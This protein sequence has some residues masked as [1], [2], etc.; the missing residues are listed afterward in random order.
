M[1]AR[2]VRGRA[3]R[4][5][6]H[7]HDQHHVD[8]DDHHD[9]VL[10]RDAI[11]DLHRCAPAC[12]PRS[13]KAINTVA[14]T[15]A[16]ESVRAILMKE[17][18]DVVPA[19]GALVMASGDPVFP[20]YPK[21]VSKK[22]ID[23]RPAHSMTTDQVVALAPGVYAAYNPGRSRPRHLPDRP[24]RG[25][26]APSAS[27][28]SPTRAGRAGTE[29]AP[30]PEAEEPDLVR[31]APPRGVIGVGSH[32]RELGDGGSCCCS[33]RKEISERSFYGG[34]VLTPG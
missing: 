15:P 13:P 30:A 32:G 10:G 12:A 11:V 28:T 8:V 9:R 17:C 19:A 1:G 14:G 4:G 3:R 6:G 18:G 20:G 16:N 7:H 5:R 23:D 2:Q 24:E 34:G 29:C 26:T 25:A 31:P 22:S 27:A 21:V 33:P